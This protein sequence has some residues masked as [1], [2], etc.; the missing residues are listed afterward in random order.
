MVRRMRWLITGGAGFV[1][2]HLTER[3][4]RESETVASIDDLSTGSIGNI[5]HLRSNPNY[6][7]HA[8]TCANVPLMR[9]LV[10]DADIVVHLAAAVG[11]KLIVQSPVRTIETNIKLTEVV[12][13]AAAKKKKKVL[14]AS[15][16]EVYGKGVKFPFGEEDDLLLG[17]SSRGR[18]SYAASKLIDE[19]LALAY[20]KERGTPTIVV[21]L[22]NTVGP[23]Q[24]GM[25]GMVIPSFVR[26]ALTNQ[27]ITVY[28]D[29]K[30][31]RCF[32]HVHDVVWALHQLC[33]ADE[34]K[35]V[36]QVFNVGA[37]GEISIVDLAEKI[38][39]MVGSDSDIVHIPYDKAYEVGFEDM[40]RRVPDTSKLKGTIGYEPKRDLDQIL[41]DVIQ[42]ERS[43]LSSDLR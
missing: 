16:S 30:Q 3:L 4:L 7:F 1:G 40:A 32:G 43:R 28:G 23:R 42:F 19:F 33:I 15:T 26:Q 11:V 27:P 10:D 38:K 20:A 17:P 35:T 13:D 6:V 9:E 34:S 2:S 5:R 21:R 36:G 39:T 37:Q 8:D 25:Y 29:G 31:S 41:R 24:T 14:V 12:L 18:W 22:F